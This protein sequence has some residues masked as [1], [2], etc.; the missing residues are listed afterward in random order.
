[1]SVIMVIANHFVTPLFLGVPTS[2]VDPILL[3]IILPFNLIKAG[4]NSVVTFLVYK[5]VSKY[6]VHGETFGAKKGLTDKT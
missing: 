4:I 2:A 5:A 6:I 1:M 3:P